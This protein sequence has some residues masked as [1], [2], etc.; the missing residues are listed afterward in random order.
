MSAGG[1]ARRDRQFGRKTAAS[2]LAK[3]VLVPS[4]LLDYAYRNRFLLTGTSRAAIPWARRNRER[5]HKRKGVVG[6]LAESIFAGRRSISLSRRS[7]TGLLM[8]RKFNL[9]SDWT[10]R[11][12]N[13]NTLEVRHAPNDVIFAAIF[14]LTV[15]FFRPRQLATIAHH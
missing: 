11:P 1:G 9:H 4:K 7:A 6:S 10:T 13:V 12:C 3:M 14:R 2:L 15:K 5:R 8:R